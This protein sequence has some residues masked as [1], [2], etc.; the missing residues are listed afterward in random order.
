MNRRPA[1]WK[2]STPF[3]SPTTYL[4]VAQTPVRNV[5][6]LQD[7]GGLLAFGRARI[8]DQAD[9][10]PRARPEVGN[11]RGD[12]HS[13][14]CDAGHLFLA[15]LKPVVNTRIRMDLG[16]GINGV[17]CLSLSLHG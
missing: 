9:V 12:G 6:P 8:P 5:A 2:K 11:S 14:G 7:L 1:R 15:E 4:N 13:A 3:F 16:E 10:S 17:Y